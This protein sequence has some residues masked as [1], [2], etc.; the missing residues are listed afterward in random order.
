MSV[1]ITEEDLARISTA[2]KGFKES[3][4]NM[5]VLMAGLTRDIESLK[6]TVAKIDKR[7][8][9]NSSDINTIK[10]VLEAFKVEITLIKDK[11]S[12]PKKKPVKPKGLE[13]KREKE[14]SFF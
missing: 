6:K 5:Q 8:F 14:E 2:L 7:S 10:E 9:N 1:P 12:L 11:I 4:K 13:R 3:V